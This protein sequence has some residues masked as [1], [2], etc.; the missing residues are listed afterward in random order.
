MDTNTKTQQ[1][2]IFAKG[3]N[4]DV[5]DAMISSD[6]YRMANNLRY[7]TNDEENSGELHVIEGAAQVLD[8]VHGTVRGMVSIREYGAIVVENEDEWSVWRFDSKEDDT[9]RCYVEQVHISDHPL[10]KRNKLSLVTKYEDESNIKM[11]IAD[12]EHPVLVVNIM[13]RNYDDPE[14][15]IITDYQKI[16]S[17]PNT[18]LDSPTFNKLIN[19]TL[20][21]GN[22]Q[23][24]YQLYNT[25]GTAT[26]I[27]IPTRII[28]L[29]NK[30][31]EMTSFKNFKGVEQGKVSN[32]GVEFSI[33][34]ETPLF[35]K[36]KI[37]RITYVEAGQPPLI[38][39]ILDTDIWS[40]NS[41]MTVQ[42]T[43]Y[44]ALET[45]TVEEY[46]GMSGIHIIPKVIE[47]KDDYMFAACIETAQTKLDEKLSDKN[48]FNFSC[49][50]TD[51]GIYDMTK[52]LASVTGS[53]NGPIVSWQF[54]TKELTGDANGNKRELIALSKNSYANPINTYNYTS[55]R[56]DELYRFGIV[57]YDDKGNHSSVFWVADVRTPSMY[58]DGYQTFTLNDNE[59][60]VYALGIQFTVN[61]Q[62]LASEN[63]IGYEIVRC[64]RTE[65]DIATIAQGVV[66]RPGRR[67]T[68]NKD[69]WVD[70][71]PL[72]P[73]GWLTT[74]NI[75]I[76]P[77]ANIDDG[78][79]QFVFDDPEDEHVERWH[80][81]NTTVY[82]HYKSVGNNSVFQFVCP[83]H[84]YQDESFSSLLDKDGLY[85]KQ[86]K[87]IY[88]TH[89]DDV[90]VPNSEI[91]LP[92]QD[93]IFGASDLL[94][95]PY[96]T[97]DRLKPNTGNEL[98]YMYFGNTYTHLSYLWDPDTSANF[99]PRPIEAALYYPS[100]YHA[101]EY[102]S[103][104]EWT[105]EN[106]GSNWSYD[107]ERINKP[108]R[109]QYIKLYQSTDTIKPAKLNSTN[110][111]DIKDIPSIEVLST[112]TAKALQWDDYA[113]ATNQSKDGE[114]YP[115]KYINHLTNIGDDSFV[116]WVAQN[117]YNMPVASP[118]GDDGWHSSNGNLDIKFLYPVGSV[119]GPG[120]KTVL[121]KLDTRNGDYIDRTMIDANA[122]QHLMIDSMM[123]TYL[124][125]LRQNTTP[126]G[127]ND[128]NAKKLCNYYS[129]GY[130][131]KT[132]DNAPIQVYGGD[133]FIQ[134]F[135]YVSM[136]K[137][138]HNQYKHVRNTC[139]V[140][141][142]PVETNINLAYTY[143]YEFSKNFTI[144]GSATNLQDQPSD[145]Y[146]F[147]TQDTPLYQYNGTYSSSSK[148]KTFAAYQD[149][150]TNIENEDYRCYYSN[151]KNNNE[152]IDNW[153]I[154]QPANFLDVD[155]RKGPIT[156]LR[157]FHNH[158]VF[159]QKDATGLF[160]VNERTA[161]T[162]DSNMPLLLG[163]GG[164]LARY[165][166]I[167]TFNGMHENEF[168]DAQSDSTLYW[169]DH[170]RAD[171]CGYAGGESMV[172][173][174]KVKNIQNF[175]NKQK[176]NGKLIDTKDTPML[177][178]DKKYNE[179]IASVSKGEESDAGSL[180]Y[181]EQT[182]CFTGLYGINPKYALSFTDKLYLHQKDGLYV[183]NEDVE[184]EAYGL[185]GEEL[186]PYL[187]Y[188][189][190]DNQQFNKVFDNVR[191][192]ARVYGG[193][194]MEDGERNN[195]ALHNLTF[196][197]ST[198]LKQASSIS[199]EDIENVEYDFRFAVPRNGGSDYGD[200]MRGKTMQCEL[201]SESNSLDLS[202]QYITTK[203]RISWT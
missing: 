179:L 157:T 167:N 144:S 124:C 196:T 126:Y 181:S 170:D 79:S 136:H 202:I 133:C 25:Y 51:A 63:I 100:K 54:I 4:A 1:T 189:V 153:T 105:E 159:W 132:S 134:P 74:A 28:P 162:D 115:L 149:D 75:I 73:T 61:T 140:Y 110:L 36:I 38:E 154:Y 2:N 18:V 135:E 191:F 163:T 145:V 173:L 160:S 130:Y 80:Y 158:L 84:A 59:L 70:R 89:F 148:V 185:E 41:I 67:Y 141:S 156:G 83:E 88:G 176:N 116:N 30:A 171:I 161:I 26:D 21:E 117:T 152:S 58:I 193:G 44:E 29:H 20:K 34:I 7:V 87:Y 180:I 12:G 13:T 10:S 96:S 138:Y 55:L 8:N 35:Q 31:P 69:E 192:G 129:Y 56:R 131:K 195:D 125:N 81:S 90:T 62:L 201:K 150:P 142:I 203:Y 198:P 99:E 42:D 64:N 137:Y 175:L 106:Y 111:V 11:Y 197:F 33:K 151:P 16:T 71:F 32:K 104:S 48:K 53:Y 98:G 113:E 57:L 72:T 112:S 94:L 97:V 6:Q 47:S 76:S 65:K 199:G 5:S 78:T 9:D 27:S 114:S 187:K 37:Y 60:K 118:G 146:G 165:D 23:Y 39:L 121:L 128:D 183:W 166:Y 177:T 102:Y 155:T 52:P 92:V 182:Q 174:S 17:Y 147:F 91:H 86:L 108:D 46:N 95:R 68:L 82:S 169:W 186:K 107:W 66:S 43:G 40:E 194:C 123:G 188:I 3:M 101:W 77:Y 164:V 19:G 168:A 14:D 184:D 119:C 85:L 22:V 139:I 172:V 143:G 45:L 200:R 178:F 24:S 49:P 122:S 50:Q 127:G 120:G 103:K 190:N 93:D 15:K 109:H